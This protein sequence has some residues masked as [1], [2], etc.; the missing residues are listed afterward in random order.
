MNACVVSVPSLFARNEGEPA[1]VTAAAAA[2]V[3]RKPRRD[4][5]MAPAESGRTPDAIGHSAGC[6]TRRLGHAG[7]F[8]IRDEPRGS[9]NSSCES[10]EYCVSQFPFVLVIDSSSSARTAPVMTAT[11]SLMLTRFGSS[12]AA[13][14]PSRAT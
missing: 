14:L 6:Q 8:R 7:E 11:A 3:F 5:D 10:R 12:T 9:T 1:N 4:V 13:R 2:P